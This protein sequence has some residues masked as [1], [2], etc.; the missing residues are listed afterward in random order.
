MSNA[1]ARAQALGALYAADV[2]QRDVID[3]VRV[4]KRAGE[5]A[6]AVW[7][8]REAIDAAIDEASNDWRIERMSAVDRN[9]L[10]LATYEL[11]HTDIPKG[12]AMDEAIELAKQYSTGKSGAFVNGVLSAFVDA[13]S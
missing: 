7:E 4:S 11:L 13:E 6:E 2:L 12:I 10:R 8:R 9:I 5:L 1:G 3:T